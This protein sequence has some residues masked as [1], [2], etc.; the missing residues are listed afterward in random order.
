MF[1]RCLSNVN[2]THIIPIDNWY[3]TLKDL[4]EGAYAAMVPANTMH[5]MHV[6]V[7][8]G[9]SYVYVSALDGRVALHL[10]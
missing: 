9:I 2:S 6:H 4:T 8:V 5:T 10:Q 3:Y 1:G 7:H